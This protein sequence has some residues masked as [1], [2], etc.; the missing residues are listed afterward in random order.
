MHFRVLMQFQ[1]VKLGQI[2]IWPPTDLAIRFDYM[3]YHF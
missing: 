1:Q 2:I 3:A